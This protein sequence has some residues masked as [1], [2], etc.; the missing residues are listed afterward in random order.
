MRGILLAVQVYSQKHT[1]QRLR[2]NFCFRLCCASQCLWCCLPVKSQFVIASMRAQT[3]VHGTIK[4]AQVCEA[5][6]KVDLGHI[7]LRERQP[8]FGTLG[9]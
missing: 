3:T 2:S 1:L 7:G 9:H 6:K 5:S 4:A 8:S